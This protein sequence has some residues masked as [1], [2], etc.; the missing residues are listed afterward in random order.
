MLRLAEA[1]AQLPENQ[2]QAVELHHLQGF[3]L[4]E[5]A[6]Q[7]GRSKS[8]VAALL[9]RGLEKLRGLLEEQE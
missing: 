3:S 9:F 7:M 4:V 1:V 2:R 8:A 6:E 5:V